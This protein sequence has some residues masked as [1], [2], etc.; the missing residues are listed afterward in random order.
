MRRRSAC[1]VAALLL[2]SGFAIAAGLRIA[3]AHHGFSGRYDASQPIWIEGVVEKASVA[4]P[5]PVLSVRVDREMRPPEGFSLPNEITGALRVRAE[6]R[7]AVREIEFPPTATFFAL[8]E[9]VKP[10][11]RVALVVLRNCLAPHQLRSQWVRLTNGT[12]IERSGRLSAQAN[13]C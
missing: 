13:G 5:H 2:V 1:V 10:G 3:S 9:R 4:P 6:D 12:V 7:G 11:D 8:S